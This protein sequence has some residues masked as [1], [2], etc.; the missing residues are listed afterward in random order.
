MS[1]NTSTLILLEQL[2]MESCGD[3]LSFETTTNITTNKSVISTTL[4]QYDDGEDGYFDDRWIHIQGVTNPDVERKIGSTTYDTA[5]G[6]CY[7]YGANLVAEAA[8][9][10]CRITRYKRE[11]YKTALLRAIE[12]VYGLGL[13]YKAV[14]DL[15]L[16]TGNRA[17]DGHFES[18]SSA[19]ALTYWTASNITLAQTSTAGLTRGGTYSAKCTAGAA[20]GYISI[21]SNTYPELLD[22][23]GRTIDAYVQA[24]PQTANDA[25]IVIYTKQADGTEQT[26]TS[27]TATP[28]GEFTE[29]KHESQTINDNL[30]DFEIRLK[31]TTNGQYVYYDDLYVGDRNLTRYLLPDSFVGGKLEQVWMQQTGQSNE[32]FYDLNS[33]TRERG[34]QLAFVI[35]SNGTNRYLELMEA[36]PNKR[37]LR[38]IGEAPLETLSATTDTITLD[39]WRIPLLIAKAR[40][41]FWE[42]ES[43]PVSSEDSSKFEYEYSKAARD[44][45]RLLS[46]KMPERIEY[47]ER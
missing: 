11:K 21:H 29:I 13:L 27:T 10:T 1:I 43:V 14:D 12:E 36:P 6:T 33:F 9:M 38:L 18:W 40:M 41:I 42:R 23:Q 7:V 25:N 34:K 47:Q 17:V 32:L 44:Y 45:S 46:N 22:F 24:Y 35:T 19:T 20:N 4:N 26:L 5:T 8:A 39:A 30:T 16:V 37:R 2:L 31:V 15:T 28:A 3:Y